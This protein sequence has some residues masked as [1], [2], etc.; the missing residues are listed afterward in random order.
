ML[1][2]GP[3]HLGGEAVGHPVVGTVFAEKLFDHGPAAMGMDDEAGA[4]GVMED[5]GPPGFLANAHAGLVRLQDGAGEELLADQAGL[6]GAQ[7][8]PERR[9]R[10]QAG[11]RRGH[12][13]LRAARADAAVQYHAR[14]VGLDLGN[15]DPVVGASRPLR[16]ARDI[17]PAMLA[18]T[19]RNIAMPGRVRM[20][21]PMR[22]G[23]R[24]AL[25]PARGL[26]I[27]LV[28]RRRRRARIVRR[29]R[30]QVELFAQRRVLAL[31]RFQARQ[32]LH[33][34]R[35]LILGAQQ[36]EIRWREHPALDSDSS[37]SRHSFPRVRVNSPHLLA[38]V[39][40]CRQSTICRP[41]T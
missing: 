28:P 33:D 11:R 20:Q 31:Q 3:F 22:P 27:A 26:A 13:R 38:A 5:P 18:V 41:G 4:V 1:D 9:T 24:L 32:Q 12:E 14:H 6:C 39:P 15:L 17:R 19:R 29:L 34:Q 7:V 30:R 37:P 25:G 10:L 35:V 21:L 36:N 16:D 40:Q 8:R 23:M 2:P